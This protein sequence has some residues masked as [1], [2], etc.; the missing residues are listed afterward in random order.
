LF[1][2]FGKATRAAKKTR[3]ARAACGLRV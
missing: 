2:N 3:E 1:E